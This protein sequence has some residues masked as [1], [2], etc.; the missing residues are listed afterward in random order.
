[1][2]QPDIQHAT[3]ETSKRTATPQLP[4]W[5]LLKRIGGYPIDAP[6]VVQKFRWQTAV[7]TAMGL[8]DSDW[9][10]AHK[11]RK[12]TIGGVCRLGPYVTKTW[13]STQQTIAVSSAE[14]GLY[15][16]L[17]CA[18]QTL[19]VINLGLDFGLTLGAA[20][21]ADASA[22][23]VVT[24]R[25]GLNKL[26]HIAA[27]RLWIQERVKAGD[28]KEMKIKGTEN[29]ADLFTKH[30]PGDEITKHLQIMDFEIATGR[31][32]KSLTVSLVGNGDEKVDSKED[33][34]AHNEQCVVRMRVEPR[35][36]L[37]F[38]R[39]CTHSSNGQT[40]R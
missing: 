8:S 14:V 17:K 15:A 26:C 28:I 3:Q 16:L 38:I 37:V 39:C 25:Q 12:S 10:G 4:H 19:G 24:H 34:W 33:Y 27:Q 7:T 31:A 11:T 22:A 20:V 30:L 6:R 29:P 9:A 21:H 40:S 5:N 13:P 35:I 2:D 23:L 32:N 36:S 18:C 1:M